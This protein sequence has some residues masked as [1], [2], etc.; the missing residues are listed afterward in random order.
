MSRSVIDGD[1]QRDNRAAPAVVRAPLAAFL[2]RHQL[3]RL[4][5]REQPAQLDDARAAVL[6]VDVCGFSATT[7]A[8]AAQGRA[9]AELLSRSVAD[10]FG[11]VIAHVHRY[12]GDV[13][14][15]AGD[16][17]WALWP[18]GT[19]QPA[20]LAAACAAAA[21]SALDIQSV[22][23]SNDQGAPRTFA[24]RASVGV[25]RIENNSVGGAHGPRFSVIIGDAITD[26]GR[27]GAHAPEGG[28]VL[29]GAA[30]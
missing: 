1:P 14:V 3:A 26:A 12:G 11:D 19:G 13:M 10:T 16:A 30:R 6:F 28:V 7:L 22:S 21:Q 17:V 20:E 2:P 23:L 9:G 27:A 4:S 15:F 18:V 29:S 25:G 8:Y 24:L 5:G